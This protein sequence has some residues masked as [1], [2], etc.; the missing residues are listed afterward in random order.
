MGKLDEIT[1][2]FD[3][4]EQAKHDKFWITELESVCQYYIELITHTGVYHYYN[5]YVMQDLAYNNKPLDLPLITD[6][7]IE[8]RPWFL[9]LPY[10]QTMLKWNSNLNKWEY[11]NHTKDSLSSCS[12]DSL[13]TCYC[14]DCSAP[15]LTS[16]ID[17]FKIEDMRV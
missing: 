17:K 10:S 14:N 3:F 15:S 5:P 11:E 12:L 8:E 7:E 13:S 2:F 16:P 4:D 1:I 9:F 6:W